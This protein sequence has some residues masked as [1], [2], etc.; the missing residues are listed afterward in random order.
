MFATLKTELANRSS[1]VADF[2]RL[3]DRLESEEIQNRVVTPSLRTLKGMMFVQFYSV[4]EYIL[5]ASFTETIRQ[6]NSHALQLCD[7][8]RGLLALVMHSDFQSISSISERRSWIQKISLFDKCEARIDASIAEAV[9]PRDE[10]HFRTAQL[11]TICS[12]IG[13]PANGLLPQSRLIGWISEVVEHRNAIAH[14]RET[15]STIGGRYSSGDLDLRRAQ[16]DLLCNHIIA[17]LE[18]HASTAQ[19]FKK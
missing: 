9:F 11:E 10:S 7:I 3:I 8:K 19:N 15:A 2:W 18:L 14:G 5:I 17:T 12:T 6:F 16:M 1:E 13:L 4:Y